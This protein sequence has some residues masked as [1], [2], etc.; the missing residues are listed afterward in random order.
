MQRLRRDVRLSL[1]AAVLLVV[2]TLTVAFAGVL[3]LTSSGTSADTPGYALTC[4][5]AGIAIN[6]P[7]VVTEG[8]FTSNPANPGATDNLKANSPD[9]P[10]SS[11]GVYNS[12]TNPN[13][14]NLL[15]G[16]DT[17]LGLVL[18][19]PANLEPLTTPGS[20]VTFSGSVPLT[21]TGGTGTPS[22]AA[23][24]SFTVPSS[25]PTNAGVVITATQSGTNI[26]A[27]S[28]G[29]LS[30][31]EP[32]FTSGS[33]LSLTIV[34][35][36]ASIPIT[37]TSSASHTI[38]T[39]T[40]GTGGGGTTTTTTSSTTTTT[41][42]ST[43]TTTTSS[44][45]TTTTPPSQPDTPSYS[46]SCTAASVPVNLPTAITEGVF[47]SNP[48]AA[49]AVDNLK[50]NSKAVP[51]SLFGVYNASSNPK[52]LNLLNGPDAGLG[53]VIQFPAALEPLTTPGAIVTFSGTV[54]LT[55]TGGTG[56]PSLS[57]SGSFTVPTTYPTNA[58]VVLQVRRAE[59]SQRASKRR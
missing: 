56:T 51:N 54:P 32:Q 52:G 16:P 3:G 18:Q 9:M 8:L 39:A 31:A 47:T 22:L 13:G 19:F 53:L 55:V 14:V 59:P 25:Y 1:T 17:G 12:S 36:T 23:S 33:P 42:S 35:G 46:I 38:D 10:N 57:L 37:C 27:G 20:T 26:T 44:T 30:V 5:A 41:T 45:T 24:G 34:I 48:V 11:F 28:S 6:L 40:I 7:A 15:N 50:A 21:V 49:G 29:S 2:S 4:N 58:G 43:T